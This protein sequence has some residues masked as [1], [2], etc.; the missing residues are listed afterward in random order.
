M[1]ILRIITLISIDV[2]FAIYRFSRGNNSSD[3]I[4]FQAFY[5]SSVS[6]FL[7]CPDVFEQNN[8]IIRKQVQLPSY[9][10]NSNKH[11]NLI[12]QDNQWEQLLFI[13]NTCNSNIEILKDQQFFNQPR[14][15]LQIVTFKE[16]KDE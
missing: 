15:M 13:I 8:P 1:Q 3:F 11:K 6:H 14:N 9:I 16:V 10:N 12:L 5:I 2:E 7:V 4:R